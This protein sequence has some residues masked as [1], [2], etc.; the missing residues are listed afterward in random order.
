MGLI[1]ERYAGK[2]AGVLYCY[3]RIIVQGTLPIFCYADG[4]TKCLHARG[5]RILDFTEFAKPL[6]CNQDERREAGAAAGLAMDYNRKK[7]F[8]KEECFVKFSQLPTGAIRS[9]SVQLTI[10]ATGFGN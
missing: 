7:N 10:P 5:I 1:T 9:S 4:M 3:D 8:R 2:I 6:T